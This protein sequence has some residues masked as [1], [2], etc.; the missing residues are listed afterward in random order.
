M[1]HE[2]LMPAIP[3]LR[4]RTFDEAVALAVRCEHNFRHTAVIH[5]N[6]LR[7][8]TQ[9]GRATA[10]TLFVASAPSYAWAGNEAEG[11]C[12]MT[13]AG[14]TGEGLTTP[15]TFTRMRYV[16]MANALNVAM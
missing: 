10:C 14:P 6:D 5:S 12:A 13:V 4:V 11:I 9:F 2:Q 7:H 3:I 16:V 15:R 8:I 1:Q